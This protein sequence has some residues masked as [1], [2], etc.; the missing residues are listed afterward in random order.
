MRASKASGERR[1][2]KTSRKVTP[3]IGQTQHARQRGEAYWLVGMRNGGLKRKTKTKGDG[4]EKRKRGESEKRGG[5]ED[6]ESIVRLTFFGKS[7]WMPKRDLIRAM[8]DI[9][10]H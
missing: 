5:G 8:S 3:C 7:G 2:G 4:R 1:I 6:L 10:N 9:T